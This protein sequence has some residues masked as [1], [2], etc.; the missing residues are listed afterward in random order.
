MQVIEIPPE[1][2]KIEFSK[3]GGPG[4]QNVNKRETAVRVVH[5]PTNLSVHVATER[6]Q[7][8]NRERAIEM[9]KGK[10]FK[11][12]ED[13]KAKERAGL[14]IS[15]TTDIEWG[16]QIRSY[17]LH[18][19]KMVKD[20]RTDVEVRDVDAVLEDGAIEPFIEAEKNL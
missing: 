3:A 10:L 13:D 18:P 12:M 2:L 19:Y 4:G 20:H 6:S 16:S 15:K 7:E 14:S 9:L 11:K 1:D 17:V 8:Q 5:L